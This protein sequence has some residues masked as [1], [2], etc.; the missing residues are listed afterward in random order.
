MRR[1]GIDSAGQGL[2]KIGAS[3]EKPGFS[4]NPGFWLLRKFCM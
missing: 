4:Q 1:A 2:R 3:P